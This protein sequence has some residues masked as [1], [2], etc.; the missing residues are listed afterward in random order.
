MNY[1]LYIYLAQTLLT[2][3]GV[4]TLFLAAL[5]FFAPEVIGQ[6]VGIAELTIAAENEIRSSYGGMHLLF[7]IVYIAGVVKPQLIRTALILLVVVQGGFLLGRLYS[8][9]FSGM[10]EGE[11]VWV[12]MAQEAVGA[13]FATFLLWHIGLYPSK[14]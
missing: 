13:G 7:A 4:F 9:A 5:G 1:R 12:C 3:A 8:L 11:F 10:P 6:E 14:E 2:V